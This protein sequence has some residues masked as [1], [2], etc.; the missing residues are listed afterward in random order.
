MKQSPRWSHPSKKRGARAARVLTPSVATAL[1]VLLACGGE[2][3]PAPQTTP[4]GGAGEGPEAGEGPGTP[5]QA[6]P[7]TAGPSSTPRRPPPERAPAPDGTRTY[8]DLMTLS[9][10]ADVDVDGLFID[11]GTA[12]RLKYTSGNWGSGFTGDHETAGVTWSGF[13]TVGRVWF[14]AEDA[15]ARRIHLRLKAVGGTRLIAFVNGTEVGG[16][17][18]EAGDYRDVRLDVPASA[19][20]TGEN[21]LLLRGDATSSVMGEDVSFALDTM[22]ITRADRD[23]AE[24]LPAL[25]TS[26]NAA[27][28]RRALRLPGAGSLSYHLPIPRDTTLVVGAAHAPHEAEVASRA[29]AADS[30]PSPRPAGSSTPQGASAEDAAGEARAEVVVTRDGAE[31]QTLATIP[32]G[33]RFEDRAL[34]LGAFADQHVRITLRGIGGAVAFSDVRLVVPAPVVEPI[35]ESAHNVIV[36]TIDTLRASKLRAYNRRSRVRTPAL[37]GFAESATLF[38]RAQSAENWTKPSVASIL[39]SLY[40][41]THN[42]KYDNSS[43]PTEA[44]LVSEV[45]EGAGFA[46]AQFS[47]NGYVSD[48]FGFTQGFNHAVNYIRETRSTEAETVFREAGDWIEAQVERQRTARE[49]GESAPRFFTYIQTIDPHVP[50]DPPGNFLEMYFE[51]PYTGQIRNRSTGD[52]LGRA[53]QNPPRVVFTEEDKLRLAALHDAEISYH[54]HHLARFLARIERL[55]LNENTLFVITSDH[56]EEFEEHGSWGHGH[57]VYQELLHVPLMI[58]WPGVAPAGTRIP[59]V[60][61]TMDIAPTMLEALGMP[62]PPDFEGRSLLGYLRGTPPPGPHVAFSDYQETRRVI[63]S[64][65]S[66]LIL[67]NS[68]TFVLFDLAADPGERRE[69]DGR[70]TPI[71]LRTLRTLSGVFL[72]AADR[73]GWILGRPGRARSLRANTQMT[74]EL[75]EQLAALGYIVGDC[76]TFP[77]ERRR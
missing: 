44:L 15:S 68:G 4:S 66:K 48:R 20:R 47:A 75:C 39:T 33:D 71:T 32:L 56:G 30:A 37:D 21:T 70:A 77:S 31:P 57:S 34:D 13:G 18:I 10:L 8:M 74:R 62:S 54:D 16:G 43:L 5:P 58:R 76:S 27:A 72:G 41:A 14:P 45:L 29:Q 64:L 24:P 67:R 69:L 36:L 50:Y 3:D 46:T 1:A 73:R 65:D 59:D 53:K 6:A 38:E 40:P 60:V 17:P 61:T 12:A 2:P 9:H 49:A 25:L 51:G 26:V 35:A 7:P 11:F 55:G 19:M 52:L 22:S 63:R 28:S 42:A 23:T